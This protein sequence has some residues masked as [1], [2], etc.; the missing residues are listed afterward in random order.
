[1]LLIACSGDSTD[2]SATA[3]PDPTAQGDPTAGADPTASG[4]V[5]G[6]DGDLTVYSGRS[7][8]L[9]GP[10]IE[11]FEASSGIEVAVRYAD[12]AQLAATLLE[13]GA[14]SPADVYIAQ[15]AGALGAVAAAGLLAPLDA[16]ILERVSPTFRS[17]E[18]DWVGLSG[19]VR[20]VVYNTERVDPSELPASILDFSDPRWSG[21]AG[22]A[23]LNGSF[24]AFVTALRLTEGEE[25]ARAWLEAM[26][27]N[28][29]ADY[30]NNTA[31]V[32]AVAAGEID[33]GFV[34]HY[35]VHRF[36]AEEGDA[37][38][39]R[40]YYTAPGDPG[41]LVNVAGAAVLASSEAP[42]AAEAL[43]EFLLSG[44]AQRYFAEETFEYPLVAGVPASADLASIQDLRPVE[45]DLSRLEDLEATLAL[46]RDAGVL[47]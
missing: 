26:R 42:E 29:V 27:A 35:Y 30:A 25:A 46:M 47:P 12:T 37:F 5:E 13:E 32:A 43:I 40:N 17:A 3:N 18:G 6:G 15:D 8:E 31:I 20:T 45:L 21:R 19:R 10:L 11:R 44:E 33:V 4:A 28:E 36:L 14:R 23:S 1:M 22:W 2:S 38:G 39:A 9:I 34:N 41:T 7:E 24:Q 16:A